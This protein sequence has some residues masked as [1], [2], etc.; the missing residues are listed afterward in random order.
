MILELGMKEVY[1]YS[2]IYLSV[3]YLSKINDQ[4]I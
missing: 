2:I 4:N 1:L 3:F